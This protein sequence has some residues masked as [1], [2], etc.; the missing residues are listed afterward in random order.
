MTQTLNYAYPEYTPLTISN[1]TVHAEL[2]R[3]NANTFVENRLFG[4][5][6]P[7][8]YRERLKI[9]FNISD[10]FKGKMALIRGV[11]EFNRPLRFTFVYNFSKQTIETDVHR[12]DRGELQSFLNRIYQLI[13]NEDQFKKALKVVLHFENEYKKLSASVYAQYRHPQQ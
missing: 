12:G 11:I 8:F 7:L 1:E 5:I 13:E 10:A 4:T 3:S 9:T 6:S 2:V